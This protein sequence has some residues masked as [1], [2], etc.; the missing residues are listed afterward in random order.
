[1]FTTRTRHQTVKSSRNSNIKILNFLRSPKARRPTA[2][3]NS[4]S[5]KLRTRKGFKVGYWRT[6]INNPI[7]PYETR[8]KSTKTLQQPA[9][10]C[11]KVW[12]WRT[13]AHLFGRR[14]LKFGCAFQSSKDQGMLS[15]VPSLPAQNL[16]LLGGTPLLRPS[17]G[18]GPVHC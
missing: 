4:R 10:T 13:K 3:R 2:Q 14:S 17:R 7:H 9:A 18:S 5:S 16:F 11:L 8:K 1:M 12:H 6:K 15:E